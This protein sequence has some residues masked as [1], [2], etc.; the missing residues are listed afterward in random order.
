MEKT[1]STHHHPIFPH[2]SSSSFENHSDEEELFA[3]T[4]DKFVLEQVNPDMEK[5]E[6]HDYKVARELF[7]YAG[8]LGL[9]GADVPEA[10]GGLAMGKRTA[11]LIAEKMGF[12]G[13]FSVSFNIHSGVG[14]LPFVY[15]G[16]ESQKQKYLSRIIS[17][18]WVGAYALTEPNAGSDALSANTTAKKVADTTD[19]VLNGEKQW[20]TNAH[21]ADVYVV[22]ANTDQGMTAFIIERS[23]PGVTIGPEEKKLGIKGSSTATVI[24]EDVRISEDQVLGE[25]GKGHHIAL[26]ILNLARLKLS[27]ANI[28]TSKQALRIAIGYGK[29]R[30]QFKQSIIQFGMIQEKIANMA[31]AIYGAESSAYYTADRIDRLDK[32][33]DES[34]LKNLSAYAMDCSVNK[35]AASEVL[36]YV[37]DEAVQIHGGYGYMQEYEVERIYRDARINRI[38]EGTNEINRLTIAKSFLKKYSQFKSTIEEELVNGSSNNLFVRYASKIVN[39]IMNALSNT[40]DLRNLNQ[41]YARILADCVKELYVMKGSHINSEVIQKHQ[42]FRKKMTEILCEESYYRLESNAIV[43]ISSI[44]SEE[45]K[46]QL[47]NEINAFPVMHTNIITKKQEIANEVIEKNGYFLG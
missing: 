13:S 11:G 45:D 33:N 6:A 21:I 44:C 38:F 25:I 2:E 31:I 5:L 43:L 42:Q 27:F 17:G 20:I 47:I 16:T 41:V 9:L 34:V 15:Y 19:W 46:E 32:E 39:I 40:C 1:E 18:E 35:V 24:L 22:F 29:E 10:Y 7:K 28:G 37:V 4:I 36:D 26:N 14:T 12:A 8:D 3:K 30:K 23:T